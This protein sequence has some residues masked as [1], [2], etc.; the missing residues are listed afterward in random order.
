MQET[1]VP[2]DPFGAGEPKRR[3]LFASSGRPAVPQAPSFGDTRLEA[4]ISAYHQ[5]VVDRLE[6]GLRGIQSTAVSLM[7]EIAGEVW[8]AAGASGENIQSRILSVLSRD[9]A[10]RGLIA[11]SDE[12][13]QALDVRVARVEQNIGGIEESTNEL[14]TLMAKST[15]AIREVMSSPATAGIEDL[16]RRLATVEKYLGAAFTRLNERDQALV[17]SL[18]KQTREHEALIRQES[19]RVV[20]ALE[21]QVESGAVAAVDRLVETVQQQVQWVNSRVERHARALAGAMAAHENRVL[22]ILEKPSARLDEALDGQ[23]QAIRATTKEVGEELSRSFNE[24]IVKLAH[25]VRSD[26]E[27]TQRALR[28][29]TAKQD[30]ELAGALDER[31]ARVADVIT[32]AMGWTVEELTRR[33]ADETQRAVQV[34]MAD[35]LVSIDRRFVRLA[36]SMDQ[37]IGRLGDAVAQRAAEAVDGAVGDRL[38]QAVARL[39]AAVDGIIG[40]RVDEALERVEQRIEGVGRESRDELNRTLDARIGALARLIRA[41]NKVLAERLDVI[42][43]Q[44]AAKEAVRAVNELAA[45]L[46]G[47][48]A[49]AI[50]RRFAT[51]ADLLHRETQTTVEAVA[52]S[53]EELTRRVERSVEAINRRLERDLDNVVVRLDEAMDALASGWSR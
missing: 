42:E 20:E 16:R 52:R 1:G 2:G 28:E 21:G 29:E 39:S 44:A 7:H 23:L 12:R 38:E 8:K 4:M 9:Q 10:I 25:L 18:R 27:W 36:E 40:P 51:F 6:E 14:R 22:E 45:A 19:A 3:R 30:A 11:H 34:G 15:E 5:V 43:E 41:D 50:D 37:E 49:Q 35:L 24:R 13:Y 47:E 46:P 31:L 48:I 32:A 17:N 53:S 26:T 33:S